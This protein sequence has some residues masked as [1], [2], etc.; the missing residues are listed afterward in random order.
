MLPDFLSNQSRPKETFSSV[1]NRKGKR[2]MNDNGTHEPRFFR[3]TQLTLLIAA[4]LLTTSCFEEKRIIWSSDGSLAA[5]LE[6]G[7]LHLADADGF[8]TERL[9]DDVKRPVWVPHSRQLMT[10]RAREVGSW[11]EVAA[12]L[13]PA[14]QAYLT[15]MAEV[16]RTEFLEWPGETDDF[17][18]STWKTLTEGE[19][20]ATI[21]YIRDY[22]SQQVR[23][24]LGSEW[25]N[26]QDSDFTIYRAQIIEIQGGSSNASE[27]LFES[28]DDIHNLRISPDGGAFAENSKIPPSYT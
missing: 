14:R 23:E 18:S 5:I 19:I 28:L 10:V 6:K 26:L 24:K 25:E 7:G 4:V 17:E 8:T 27:V 22:R 13:S 2:D 12:A 3:L 1:V 21:L 9:L 11:D 16:M 20:G 15:A